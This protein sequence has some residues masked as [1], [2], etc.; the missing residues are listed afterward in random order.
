MQIPRTVA[1]T[2]SR[3]LYSS[4]I[5]MENLLTLTSLLIIELWRNVSPPTIA[6]AIETLSNKNFDNPST[7]WSFTLGQTHA[8]Q[9]QDKRQTPRTYLYRIGG[10]VLQRFGL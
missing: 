7:F 6:T 3:R 1:T 4:L 9:A 8:T 10:V 2:Q 5:Q